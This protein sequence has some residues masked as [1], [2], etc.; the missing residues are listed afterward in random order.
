MHGR[1]SSQ[2]SYLSYAGAP[3]E[4]T[5]ETEEPKE[6]PRDHASVVSVIPLSG[7]GQ[8]KARVRIPSDMD[9]YINN[10]QDQFCSR[11]KADKEHNTSDSDVTVVTGPSHLSHCP[12]VVT[13]SGVVDQHGSCS[14]VST[15]KVDITAH[16]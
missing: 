10:I 16:L 14:D 11:S 9:Q 4:P 5:L 7:G 6:S 8:H 3:M 13:V 15:G 2:L 12:V 1:H